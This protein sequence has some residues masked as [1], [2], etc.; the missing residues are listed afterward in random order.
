MGWAARTRDARRARY[1][2]KVQELY[3]SGERQDCGGC[4][5]V[6]CDVCWGDA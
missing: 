1:L 2:E 6:E 5:Y 3:E 4:G